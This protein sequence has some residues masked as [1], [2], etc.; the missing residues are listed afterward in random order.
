MEEEGKAGRCK[1]GAGEGGKGRVRKGGKV[2]LRNI[3]ITIIVNKK[4]R[5]QS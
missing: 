4:V 5:A 2:G 3:M 1:E